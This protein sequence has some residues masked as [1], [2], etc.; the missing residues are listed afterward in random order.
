MSTTRLPTELNRKENPL[1]PTENYTL[2]SFC[3]TRVSKQLTVDTFH[4][5]FLKDVEEGI[6]STTQWTTE[7]MWSRGYTYQ[8]VTQF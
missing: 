3:T 7:Q 4:K 6:C 2:Q 1:L 5:V 8:E